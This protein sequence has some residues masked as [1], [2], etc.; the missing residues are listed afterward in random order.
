MV[1][2]SFIFSLISRSKVHER[3]SPSKKL[4]I[5]SVTTKPQKPLLPHLPHLPQ[6]AVAPPPSRFAQKNDKR[7]RQKKS[8]TKEEISA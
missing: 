4:W 7:Q 8:M 6:K 2:L 5:S 1:S 3:V